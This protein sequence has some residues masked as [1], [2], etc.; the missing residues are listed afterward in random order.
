M[1]TQ[2][3]LSTPRIHYYF[4]DNPL[5][6]FKV[7]LLGY[8]D[9]HYIRQTNKLRHLDFY[10]LHLVVG[11]SGF[12]LYKDR[13][14][15]LSVGDMFFLPPNELCSYYPNPDDPWEYIF[16]EF[17]GDKVEEIRQHTN[18]ANDNPVAKSTNFAQVLPSFKHFFK[19][20]QVSSTG[21]FLEAY[22][23]FF[24]LFDGISQIPTNA[25]TRDFIE[26]ALILI[27]LNFP[28]PYFTVKQLAKE[29]HCSHSQLCRQFKMKTGKTAISYINDSR[30]DYAK[31]LLQK[32]TLT[33]TQI[34][35]MSGFN[36]YTYFLLLFKRKTGMTTSE[37][38]QQYVSR[39]K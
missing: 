38:R 18:F 22:S 13:T 21:S 23:L 32:T 2:A 27:R 39:K 30:I 4:L 26:D 11:G 7:N 33:S 12:L 31:G 3:F 36:E 29:L 24:T 6:E 20:L 25:E 35:K 34:A 14:Y 28:D 16:F 19:Q 10:T 8:N 17:T 37:Y 9:L 5:T 15:S 1:E